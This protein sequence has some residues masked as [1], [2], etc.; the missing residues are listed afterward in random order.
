MKSRA[1]DTRSVFSRNRTARAA[2]LAGAALF[3]PGVALAQ[4]EP[5]DDDSRVEEIVVTA[6]R[7]EQ[8]LQDVPIS[9][10]VFSGDDIEERSTEGLQAFSQFVPNLQFSNAPS[11]GA[12]G[13]VI[14]L[15]GVGNNDSGVEFSPG[16]G[17]YVDG[18]Y[19]GVM[20]GLDLDLVG[21][22]RME[23]LRGPQ[24][25][26][27]GRN[28]TGGAI[29]IVSRR[30]SDEF[31]GDF[32]L[33]AGSFDRLDARANL[34][35]PIIP[36]EFAARVGIASRNQ[37][38]YGQSLDLTTGDTIAELGDVEATSGRVQFLVTPTDDLE[39]QI[40]VDATRSRGGVPP[41][42]IIAMNPGAFFASPGLNPAYISNDPLTNYSNGPN[43][44]D[45]D[46][47]GASL[48]ATLDLNEHWTL[49]SISSHREV[50]TRYEIDVD[51]TPWQILHSW[52]ETEQSQSSQEFLLTGESFD[53]RLHTVL[54]VFYYKDEAFS[55]RPSASTANPGATV[56]PGSPT[57]PNWNPAG[58]QVGENVSRA[59]YGQG[60][61]ALT[62]QLSVTGG[63]R[64]TEDE[65]TAAG[66]FHA[67][68]T[69]SWDALTGRAG[70]EYR[71]NDDVMTYVSAARGY[72]SGGVNSIGSGLA[73]APFDPEFLWT[74]EVGLKSEWFDNRLRLNAALFQ[75]DFQ[76]MQ[77]RQR[78]VLSDG[79]FIAVIGNAAAA[80]I[81]G[82]ELEVEAVPVEDLTLNL[83]V[84]YL[85]AA[86]SEVDPL[87]TVA[88]GL[89]AD[90]HLVETPEWT[91][92]AGAEY[93]FHLSEDSELTARV[94]YSYRT[95]IEHEITNNP[96]L[97]QPAYGLLN[98]RLTYNYEPGGWSLAIFGTNLTDEE[99][100]LNGIDFRAAFG[101]AV[102][103]Y[104]RPAEW[105]VTLRKSF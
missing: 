2:L 32:S 18:V 9:V 15:R 97:R 80:E 44:N 94:D 82:A 67:A 79:T 95:A 65:V 89:T 76:D 22:E 39:F 46:S 10:S 21:A 4:E 3:L 20:R 41:Y 60:T 30:P 23:V 88:T 12:S 25:T 48:V 16:V 85:D 52:Q 49:R 96:L 11:S 66:P 1:F 68:D 45:L 40:S 42:H 62:D 69:F 93:A 6:Q 92:S 81:S 51:G 86:Y 26:L 98:A 57:A 56:T 36:G 7:Y 31:E 13:N 83:S 54:G 14:Y 78:I 100:I 24:G 103:Q 63:L 34:N 17:V 55:L 101:V 27:F 35:I 91:A 105:G 77:F 74:Y 38:G 102:S 58:G 61:F 70:L 75:S 71:W 59:V 73:F 37:S 50:Q 5:Q 84:G 99:Y 53:E 72:K 87:V 8:N 104:A 29:N 43:T 19:I 33:T 90:K 47:F 28:T 64:Y